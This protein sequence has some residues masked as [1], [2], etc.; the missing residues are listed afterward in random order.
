MHERLEL[1]E[2]PL[3]E[4]EER[5]QASFVEFV[6]TV[7]PTVPLNPVN[8]PTLTVEV[9]GLFVLVVIESGLAVIVKSWTMMK[10]LPVT[11]VAP[12]TAAT[13]V[14]YVPAGPLQDSVELAELPAVEMD[15]V[16]GFKPQVRPAKGEVRSASAMLPVKL[17]APVTVTVRA[18]VEEAINVT[19]FGEIVTPKLATVIVV[20]EETV[21][22]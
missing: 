13:V 20:V 10:A 3:T 4:V 7:S 11:E 19:E 18:P 5:L 17:P 2:P 12:L 15:T 6:K 8:E 1:R 22:L 16:V 21:L 14:E 9:P